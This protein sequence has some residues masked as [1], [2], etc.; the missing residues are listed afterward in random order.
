M[1][2]NPSPSEDGILEQFYWIE[3]T[4]TTFE[5][6]DVNANAAGTTSM[7]SIACAEVSASSRASVMPAYENAPAKP[8]MPVPEDQV[9]M[10][11]LKSSFRTYR[12]PR[13]R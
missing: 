5:N 1:L 4:S 12:D 6:T 10:V 7:T 9:A 8:A 11:F 13:H 3:G 2:Y